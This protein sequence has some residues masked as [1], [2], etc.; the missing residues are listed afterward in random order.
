MPTGLDLD[1]LISFRYHATVSNDNAVRLGG[2]TLDIPAGLYNLSR[3]KAKVEVRQLLDG[4][5]R[6]Y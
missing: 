5:W 1:R 2:M 3:A 6:I 4:S